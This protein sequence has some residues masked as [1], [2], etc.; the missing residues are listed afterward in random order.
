MVYLT[1][2]S[3]NYF[4]DTVTLAIVGLEINL[5]VESFGHLEQRVNEESVIQFTLL[6]AEKAQHHLAQLLLHTGWE[7][8]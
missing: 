1:N 7:V 6:L 2:D 5:I 3:H 8:V 4:T